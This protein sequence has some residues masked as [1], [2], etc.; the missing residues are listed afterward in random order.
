M[1]NKQE[2]YMEPSLYSEYRSI[3]N[4]D[5]KANAFS[6]L[7]KNREDLKKEL[8]KYFYKLKNFNL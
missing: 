8:Y 3:K 6:I 4:A 1:F 2:L 7:I 5:K